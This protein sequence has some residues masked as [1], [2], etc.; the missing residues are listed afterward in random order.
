LTP[1]SREIGVEKDVPTNHRR[2]AR[3]L[4]GLVGQRFDRADDDE[5]GGH[6]NERLD[7]DHANLL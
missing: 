2:L 3:R 6:T 5:A 7:L 1:W 4:A